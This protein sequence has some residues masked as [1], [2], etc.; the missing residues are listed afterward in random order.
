MPIPAYVTTL[1]G[2]MD[3]ARRTQMVNDNIFDNNSDN[4]IRLIR[5]IELESEHYLTEPIFEKNLN[6]IKNKNICKENI[7]FKVNNMKHVGLKNLGHTCYIN[8]IIQTLYNID[9]FREEILK[10]N[11][12]YEKNNSLYQLKNLFY[13]MKNCKDKNYYNPTEFIEN[14]EDEKIDINIEF[15]AQEFLEK[16]ID[17]L[18]YRL[19]DIDN[20]ELI[21]TFF[22]GEFI[23][24]ISFNNGCNHIY[25]NYNK[26]YYVCLDIKGFNNLYE[27][28]NDFTK[29]EKL[30]KN[31]K[32]ECR[33]CK[34]KQIPTL[35]NSFH[36]LPKIL[37]IILKR[38]E[39]NILNICYEK[40]ND[41]FEFPLE[42]ELKNYINIDYKNILLNS[43]SLFKLK[44]F[45]I[46][47]GD[48]ETG[49]YYCII[50]D[51]QTNNWIKYDDSSVNIFDINLLSVEAF[52]GNLNSDLEYSANKSAYIL[53]YE[54]NNASNNEINNT[55]SY[56][57]YILNNTNDFL[58][59]SNSINNSSEGNN[60]NINSS[61]EE[62]NEVKNLTNIK[63]NSFDTYNL[64]YEKFSNLNLNN[65]NN[66]DSTRNN[67]L[68][69]KGINCNLLNLLSRFPKK[70][71]HSSNSESSNEGK[72]LV[73]IPKFKKKLKVS[74]IQKIK[75]YIY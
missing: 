6:I 52:G 43:D 19:N 37:L 55:N 8:T 29:K 73:S 12:K 27:S 14:F 68:N 44:G 74:N 7:K 5:L 10:I 70:R 42:I 20:N 17:K 59:E 36:K 66:L 22:E 31:N 67:N 2:D 50:R 65:N 54:K 69:Y 53:I 56:N 75:Y 35:Y 32:L 39:F 41:F 63:G 4:L 46:H 13:N 1:F 15:D 28:L 18:E 72:S 57:N 34:K 9:N 38:F 25:N 3:Y 49:H 33:I 24:E 21:K 62:D 60:Y 26:F 40:I 64:F 23:K 71:K 51:G 45:I 30:N 16:L 11:I 48:K 58:N 61:S 47:N